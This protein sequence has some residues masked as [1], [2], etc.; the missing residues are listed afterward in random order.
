MK[1]IPRIQ[2]SLKEASAYTEEDRLIVSTGRM[3]RVW[4]WTEVGFS[5]SE[6][7]DAET[8]RVW[9]N[10]DGDCDWQLPD[11]NEPSEAELHALTATVQD[12]EGFTSKHVC[13]TADI[14]YPAAG[15]TLR[16]TVWAYPNAG[17][18]RTQ[19]SACSYNSVKMSVPSV[20]S[21][22]LNARVDRIPIGETPLRRRLFGYYN[23][24]Q[25]RNDPHLDLL[26]EEVVTA[27]LDGNQWCN[28]ASVACI[29]DADAGIA[30]V[31]ESRT[32]KSSLY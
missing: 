14:V 15:I 23:D 12:D 21:P 16:F 31:K 19:L 9:P 3:R 1:K 25:R 2:S 28:W 18:L 24:T 26:K 8:G 22:T 13:V 11:G 32:A 29:E 7:S 6:I 5:T 17:G 4:R 10:R 27:P 30:L 20:N